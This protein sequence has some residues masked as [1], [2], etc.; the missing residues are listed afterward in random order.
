[1]HGGDVVRSLADNAGARA[2][3]DRSEGEELA[4]KHDKQAWAMVASLLAKFADA[5]IS[6]TTIFS[7]TCPTV[8]DELDEAHFFAL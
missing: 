1:M 4:A 8:S 5:C 2:T 6:T 7:S 3:G